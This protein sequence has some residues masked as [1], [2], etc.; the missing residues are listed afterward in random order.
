MTRGLDLLN[1][2]AQVRFLEP[3]AVERRG[4]LNPVRS[5]QGASHAAGAQRAKAQE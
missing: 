5:Q 2:I 1:E 4:R 3:F